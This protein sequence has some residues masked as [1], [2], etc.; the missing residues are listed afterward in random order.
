MT[1]SETPIRTR[2][3]TNPPL[4]SRNLSTNQITRRPE[5]TSHNI[6]RTSSSSGF[7]FADDFIASNARS[8]NGR[9]LPQDYHATI[10]DAH[11]GEHSAARLRAAFV[12]TSSPPFQITDPLTPA[13]I[14]KGGASV[15]M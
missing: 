5:P 4:C 15:T 8:P 14:E 2:R 13:M 12:E 6:S 10:V 9:S 1:S 3:L 11:H 7:D